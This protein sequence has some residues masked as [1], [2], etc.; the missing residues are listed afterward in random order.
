MDLVLWRHAQAQDRTP[1]GDDMKR[2]LSPRGEKQA[3]HMAS[4]LERQLPEGSRIF[5][6]PSVRTDQTVKVLGRKFKLCPGLGP[7]ASAAE[8]LKLVGWPH[9]KGATLLLGHQPQLGQLVSE[10][11]GWPATDCEIKKGAVCWLRK[12]EGQGA[13]KTVVVA[14]QSPWFSLIAQQ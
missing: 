7:D 1:G 5:A 14:V 9:S 10:L 13:I 8:L 11:M 12:R 2:R 4:W 6:S 3:A